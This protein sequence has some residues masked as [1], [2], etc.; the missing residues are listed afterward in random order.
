MHLCYRF[1]LLILALFFGLFLPFLSGCHT[2]ALYTHAETQLTGKVNQNTA[3]IIPQRI[4]FESLDLDPL[5]GKP[6]VINALLFKPE[7]AAARSLPAVVALHGCGGMYSTLALKRDSLSARHQAMAELLVAEGYAVLFPD[8]FRP[9][10]FEEICSLDFKNRSITQQ[11]IRLDAQGALVWLQHRENIQPEHVAILGW[12]HGGSAVLATLNANQPAVAKWRE[13][14]PD[15]PYFAAGAV[16]YPGCS[17]S[18]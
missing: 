8:S 3:A 9:R 6:V 14:T 2:N 18:L 17:E 15:A 13:R 11:N 12:S 16:F 10:G 7:D 5:T 4:S 1:D